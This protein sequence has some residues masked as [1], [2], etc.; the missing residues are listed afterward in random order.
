MRE[1]FAG[2]RASVRDLRA[3]PL[4]AQYLVAFLLFNDAVQA[5][6]ALST[7]VLTQELFVARGR[8]ADDATG[9]LL[10]LVLL[11]QVVAVAGALLSARLAARLGAR[12]VL[13][14]TLVVWS[15]VVVYAVVGLDGIGAAYL[16]GVVIA[17]VLGGSQALARSLYSRMVPAGRQTSF[18]SFYELAERGTAWI[19]ALVFAVVFEV[20]GSYRLALLSLLALFLTGGAI[21]AMTDT[22]AAIEAAR[23]R[24]ATEETRA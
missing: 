24:E 8:A 22:D 23:E 21:L 6:I 10:S 4:T 2:L 18:F 16:M 15:L 11:I 1:A 17:L 20:T 14:G 13:L 9:F 3:L 7:V 5:V 12:T 19:G